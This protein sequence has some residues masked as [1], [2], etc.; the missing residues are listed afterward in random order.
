MNIDSLMSVIPENIDAALIVTPC[1][2]RYFTGF[3]SSDGFLLVTRK[4]S[5]FYTDSRYI[6]AAEKQIKC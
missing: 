1:N 3:A 5:I 2:R 6:E 4:G